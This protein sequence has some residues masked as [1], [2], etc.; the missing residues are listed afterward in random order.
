MTLVVCL[1]KMERQ[2]PMRQD[3]RYSKQMSRGS[4]ICQKRRSFWLMCT[5]SL[6][7]DVWRRCKKNKKKKNGN[8]CTFKKRSLFS[9]CL[10][11]Y[12]KLCWRNN[13]KKKHAGEGPTL[14]LKTKGG[15]HPKLLAVP[16]KNL[17]NCE[18]KEKI[19]CL[20]CI[21][22]RRKNSEI[23]YYDMVMDIFLFYRVKT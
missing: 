21:V 9:A 17:K 15:R 23:I 22:N 1:P 12:C 3:F 10:I 16:Q 8:K 20:Q 4:R 6:S 13:R 19:Q 5:F 14:D 2:T 7:K 11:L 18:G